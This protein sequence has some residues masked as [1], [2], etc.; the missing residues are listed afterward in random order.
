MHT[1]PELEYHYL[2][3][4]PE[5]VPLVMSWWHSHWHASM[6]DL[7]TFTQDFKATLGRHHLPL[8]V[9]AYLSGYPVATAALKEHELT[10]CY[11]NYRCWLGSV[12][13]AP[14]HRG[15]GIAH[16]LTEH[17][18]ELAKRRHLPQLYLQTEHLSGGLY[19]D[20]GWRPL[21]LR[22]VNG[23]AVLIMVNPLN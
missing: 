2:A 18:I 21:D 12:Y 10:E 17:M 11:P 8:D 7:P 5:D 3:D 9:I 19:K 15:L 6:G 22:R 4:R 13:V 16:R 23:E 20:L 1:M 14:A